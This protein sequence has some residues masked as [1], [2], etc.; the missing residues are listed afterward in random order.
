M[1][2]MKIRLS[3]KKWFLIITVSF[4]FLLALALQMTTNH[5]K[6]RLPHERAALMWDK[7]GN[8]AHISVF[9]SE[10]EKNALKEDIEATEHLIQSWYYNLLDKT[11][12]VAVE[13]AGVSSANA[14]KVIYGCYANG[15]VS[16]QNGKKKLDVN[17]YGVG[18][19]FFQFHPIKLLKGSYFS[20]SDLMQDR[21]IIDT[22][23]AWQLFGSDD[24]VGMF[25]TIRDVPHMVVGVYER[26]RGT[27][28]DAAGNAESRIY[29]SHSS[30]RDFGSYHGL[31]GVEFFVPNPV[32][33]FGKGLVEAEM[34]G[35]K[36]AVVEHENRFGVISLTKV[37]K[38]LP[39][40]SM[41]LSGITYP[42]WENMARSY[43]DILARI[44][45]VKY[46]L[47][48]YIII[49]LVGIIW[50]LWLHRTWR[51]KDIYEKAKDYNYERSVKRHTKKQLKKEKGDEL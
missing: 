43:E 29:V 47:W 38:E 33:S 19:D 20:Q 6:Q 21:I 34:Q 44:L 24:I 46:I 45:I 23:T 7:E 28:L 16:L 36:V 37:I 9:F 40:R 10:G 11:K 42:A 12:E 48:I 50:H 31:E 15:K 51:A 4:S 14:R 3:K 17:A 22:E 49:V 39:T 8:T 41:S 26:E 27:L 25:V 2:R 5:L 32:R 18:G 35:R 13:T 30:L 1:E